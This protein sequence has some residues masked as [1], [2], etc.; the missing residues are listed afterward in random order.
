MR[1]PKLAPAIDSLLEAAETLEPGDNSPISAPDGLAMPP[2]NTRFAFLREGTDPDHAREMLSEALSL[3]VERPEL[4]AALAAA[5][6]RFAE[7]PEGSLA[8]QQRLRERKLEIQRRLGQMASK[9]AAA[10]AATESDL[11]PLAHGVEAH[12]TD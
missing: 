4:D 12:E 7:D 3:L 10:A 6:A 11:Q 9:R 8:E 1:D 5:T 2:D